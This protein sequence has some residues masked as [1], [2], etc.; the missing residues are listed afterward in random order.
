MNA[1]GEKKRKIRAARLRLLNQQYTYEEMANRLGG[2]ANPRYLSQI[3]N[4]YLGKGRKTPRGL[5]DNYASRLESA[6]D[7]PEG[8]F[9][10]PID[11]HQT[12]EAAPNGELFPGPNLVPRVAVPIVGTAEGGPDR[13]WEELGYPTCYGSEY[14][15]A[16][17]R[18]PS[19]YALLVS[20]NNMAPRMRPGEAIL[21]E[22]N[23]E[24][25]PGDEVVVRMKD[26]T[27]MVKIF[28][29]RR[30]DRIYLDSIGDHETIV[31]GADQIEFM[32]YVA[33]VF[34]AGSIRERR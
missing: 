17:S 33:G 26:G 10:R 3:A 9:D 34:R 27:T 20:G 18:D 6:F 1:R 29:A 22:P 28:S 2:N 8:W 5:S 25:Q 15:D 21:V 31:A 11:D 32:H 19:A 12:T 30:G 7:L 4:E 16:P 24:P 14:V 23:H 13:Q